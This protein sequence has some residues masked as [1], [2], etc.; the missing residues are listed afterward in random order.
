[1]EEVKQG[2]TVELL[3]EL[4]RRLHVQFHDLH[5][6]RQR[7]EGAAVP[8][9]ALE[10]DLARGDLDLLLGA[11]RAAVRQGFG[12]RLRQWWLPF[13]VYAAESG[14][15]YVGGEYWPSFDA[16]TP[17][18]SIV[19]DR[20]QIRTWFKRF[21]TEY[22]GAVPKGAFAA[23]FQ[24]IAWP[25]THAILP[26]YLQRNLAQ[27]LFEFRTALT[28]ILLR[29][30]ELL[31]TRLAVRAGAYTERFRVFCQNTTLLGHVAAALLSGE[32][33]ESPYLVRSTLHRLL[34]GLSQEQQ[35]GHWL[36]SARQSA[37]RVRTVGF[38]PEPP[39][40]VALTRK[41]RLPDATD[42]KLLLRHQDGGW[43]AYA[44]LPD[45][46]VLNGR[47]PHVYDELRTQRV[48]ID[49]AERE[50]LPTGY[51]LHP[52][53]E[54]RLA[55]W[56]RPNTPFI[57]LERGPDAINRLVAEQSRISPGPWWLFQRHPSG[58][59]VEVKGMMAHPGRSYVVVGE[60]TSPPP[61]TPWATEA[62]IHVSGVH[63]FN[64]DIPST[65][66]EADAVKLVAVGVFVVSDVILRP[67]G[68]VAGSWDGNGAVEWLAGEPGLLG[69]HSQL[70]TETCAV[71]VDTQRYV[72]K[73]PEVD[74]EMFLVIQD[75]AV[76][77]HDL[78]VTLL[79][80]DRPLAEGS[81][82]VT[83]RDPQ[84]RLDGA[85]SG[86]GIRLLASPSRPS[87]SDLWDGRSTVDIAGPANTAADLSVTL[88]DGKGKTL[89]EIK[90][91]V[92]LPVVPDS[93]AQILALIRQDSKFQS[94]YDAAESSEVAIARSGLGFASLI[95]DRGFRPLRWRVNRVRDGSHAAY[96]VDQT[97]GIQTSVEMF[98]VEDPLTPIHKNA[99]GNV[100]VPPRGG[101]LEATAG[102]TQV[103]IVLPTDRNR[104]L[105]MGRVH[106]TVKV[107]PRT[108]REVLRL[109]QA[110][111]LWSG[112]DLPA[113]PFALRQQDLVRDAIARAVSSLLTGMH[114]AN[115]ERRM[116]AADDLIQHLDDMRMCVG[117]SAGQKALGHDIGSR[118]WS[119][120]TPEDLLVG[121]A[122]T[123]AG[124]IRDAG[125]AQ[126]PAA[127][128]FLLLLAGRPGDIANWSVKQR[129]QLIQ[130]VIGSPVL[131]RAAR[132]AVL[133]TRA[134]NNVDEIAGGF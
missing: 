44:E 32:D 35:S 110:D 5:G 14:Y 71:A 77:V 22:G 40:K 85:S 33:E 47:L 26:T 118:L 34:E 60:Q 39:K 86:E 9:Y 122:R 107:G 105:R 96:L 57:Q 25:I 101:L 41:R 91:S 29:D 70:T 89:A 59:A 72:I 123:M 12:A 66:S 111:H 100:P 79:A 45:L 16:A 7:L 78:T 134:L 65:I 75:L 11:V 56:P 109:I 133:G 49:G 27:L 13:V 102:D 128:R 103:S 51:L 126:A 87:L 8:V 54:V 64:L 132:Y 129:D 125:M 62:A 114:W 93:W 50:T 58:V 74:D 42:P 31:G 81:L 99:L 112:A 24:I 82:L 18:W 115:L 92:D 119:W 113:D 124:T 94:S 73:W 61:P 116:E 88:R 28:S 106:P 1:M 130:G 20:D 4:H 76:G 6:A 36:A 84:V 117:E 53:L 121:F 19:G 2:G 46:S 52:G 30:P 98:T 67:V 10:H 97:D 21:A 15:G 108:P 17:Q 37:N 3:E 95:C 63:A 23:S 120:L 131:L 68:I 43:R 55:T 83:I 104:V 69:V 127:P 90:R 48:R 38:L 80:D